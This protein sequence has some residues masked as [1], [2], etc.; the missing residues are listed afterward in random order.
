MRPLPAPPAKRFARVD[1][2]RAE[3][4]FRDTYLGDEPVLRVEQQRVKDL[5]HLVGEQRPEVRLYVSRARD[6]RSGIQ[7]ADDTRR[8]SSPAASSFA[9]RARPTPR[10]PA[11]SAPPAPTTARSSPKRASKPRASTLASPSVGW[12]VPSNS[13]STS[14]SL[15]AQRRSETGARAGVRLPAARASRR[16]RSA[17]PRFASRCACAKRS[18]VGRELKARPS[19]RSVCLSTAAAQ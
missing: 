3:R 10:K 15:S 9:A 8:A 13:A 11:S 4:A 18:P 19:R 5:A 2:R 1:E 14:Q 16:C 6:L 7:G 17:Q 12:P